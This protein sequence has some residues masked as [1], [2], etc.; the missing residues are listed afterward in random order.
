ME[1]PTKANVEDFLVVSFYCDSLE[2]SRSNPPILDLIVK[3]LLE[4]QRSLTRA[5][6]QKLQSLLVP[7][8]Q[9]T[10]SILRPEGEAR[11]YHLI[12]V[13]QILVINTTGAPA[14][15]IIDGLDQCED[16]F[17]L[18]LLRGLDTMFR[19]EETT[20]L[21]KV[22]FTS[23]M[24]DSVRGYAMK[25][26]HIGMTTELVEDD[27]QRV[28]SEEV[29]RI[30][31]AR[32]IKTIGGSSVSAVI[33][34]RSNGSFLFASSVLK[35]LWHIKDTG[36]NSVFTMVT[37][38]PPTM[39]AIYQ[40]D[41]E[42]LKGERPDL[43]RLIQFLCVGKRTLFIQEARNV[44]RL[45]NAEVT[46][47]YDVVGDLNRTCP[48]LVKFGGE[49]TVEL[50][51]QTL[52]D[53]ITNTYDVSEIHWCFAKTC[54]D[55]LCRVDWV[56]WKD[57]RNYR[58]RRVIEDR[59]PFLTYA[60]AWMG[61]H[62]KQSGEASAKQAWEIWDF[63]CS[64]AGVR[65][66][67]YGIPLS[68][69]RG[70][71]STFTSP[72][73][74][75]SSSP[76]RT[77]QLSL[78]KRFLVWP[79]QPAKHDS[80]DA[81]SSTSVDEARSVVDDG[82]VEARLRDLTQRGLPWGPYDR[83]PKPPLVLLTQWDLDHVIKELFFEAFESSP[84]QV[85]RRL[86]RSVPYISSRSVHNTP[87]EFRAM[88]NRVW[89]GTTAVHYA[90]AQY[91]SALRLLLPF[92][93]DINFPDDDGA[94]PL[95]LA[96]ASGEIEGVRA[97]L[98]AGAEV[99][100]VDEWNQT[101]LYSALHS[102]SAEVVRALL[103]AGA[104]VSIL[105][106]SGYSPLEV[107]ISK[108]HPEYAEILLEYSPDL[109]APMTTGQPPAFLAS[110]I[111]STSV[112][113]MLIPL[114]DVDQVWNGD[115]L[116]HKACWSGWE[117]VVKK[118]IKHRADL[119]VPPEHI[120]KA[121]PVAIAAENSC[122]AV[123]KAL[124][125][126]GALFDAPKPGMTGP[127]HIATS[128]GDVQSV[129]MLIRAGCEIDALNE[130]DKTALWIAADA[131][132]MELVNLLISLGADPNLPRSEP[133]LLVAADLSNLEMVKAVLSGPTT[134]NINARGE[135]KETPLGI[136]AGRNNVELVSYLMD[137]GA[138]VNLPSG[139]RGF[140]PLQ[141]ATLSRD[142]AVMLKLLKGGADTTIQR[143]GGLHPFHIACE[144][145][146]IDFIEAFLEANTG[147]AKEVVNLDWGVYRTPLFIAALRGQ[148]RATEI[149]LE[150]GANPNHKTDD[151]SSGGRK[152]IHAAAQSGKVD[153]FEMILK[154][155]A[156]PD[157]EIRDKTGRTPLVFACEAG[158]EELVEHLLK[159]GVSSDVVLGTEENVT[160]SIVI[161]GSAK[162]LKRVLE[163]NPGLD[164]D[165]P[166]PMNNKTPLVLA[167]TFGSS[168][169]VSILLDRGADM[170]RP[171]LSGETALINAI[172]Y[173]EKGTLEVLLKGEALDI[174]KQDAHGRNALQIAFQ[175]GSYA[176]AGMIW[177]TIKDQATESML[178]A[179]RDMFGYN[180]FDLLNIVCKEFSYAEC[181]ERIRRD[182]QLLLD[183]FVDRG[184]VWERLGKCF[185]QLDMYSF[186]NVGF[187][188]NV[189]SRKRSGLAPEHQVHCRL[190]LNFIETV[191]YT[192]M[193]C[194]TTDLC[195]KC[196]MRYPKLG[197]R[198]RSCQFHAFYPVPLPTEKVIEPP[199]YDD[200]G[201]FL[202]LS[203][204]YEV[205]DSDKD[206]VP[207]LDLFL[208]EPGSPEYTMRKEVR[209]LAEEH[210][211]GKS[212]G[213]AGP[214]L[215]VPEEKEERPMSPRSDSSDSESE[216]EDE[217][218]PEAPLLPP[219][220]L[221]WETPTEFQLR[222]F[223]DAVL[224]VFTVDQTHF[225]LR[226]WEW[227]RGRWDLRLNSDWEAQSKKK[228]FESL[229]LRPLHSR[230]PEPLAPK[231]EVYEYLSSLAYLWA[232]R[233]AYQ[234]TTGVSFLV[235]Q[236]SA[237]KKMKKLKKVASKVIK[238]SKRVGEVGSD[239]DE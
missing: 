2:S 45:H 49:G 185:L 118:L 17:I 160:S 79:D 158:S 214:D 135:L 155:V 163:Y 183:E 7:D 157:L 164:T 234:F 218:P 97:L 140:S 22:V 152:I 50:L 72:S 38:C 198:M 211:I 123:L 139:T 31:M 24:T 223:L 176:M 10:H 59:H 227:P 128:R 232:F 21:L 199:E 32:Q 105:A 95:V 125:A 9:K 114:I 228:E 235:F 178:L 88:I 191:R 186:A 203:P 92:V 233:P 78:Q 85:F 70:P 115:R 55:H 56:D 86:L 46:D 90:A 28:V 226:R 173:R 134:P 200:S 5:A 230:L 61:Y 112:L 175:A 26:P 154:N 69:T 119:N 221:E 150:K 53:F 15:L 156:E 6:K 182:A 117:G 220:P 144:M 58:D 27:I 229:I 40:Q 109:K 57:L 170:N 89:E 81:S 174:G 108:D 99:N 75:R 215:P 196:I 25:N 33:V 181:I 34:E 171:C 4:K 71:P 67:E 201:E 132:Q 136:A 207:C 19:R 131:N 239:V 80:S 93:N 167:A 166:R 216:E 195:D 129:T 142:E 168:E 54:L 194:C 236:Q 213:P 212:D 122:H 65:M 51:H 180:T 169:I 62:W 76:T 52:Y 83:T 204:I 37:S 159:Q 63:L 110:G 224:Q 47:N 43:F 222:F 94:T 209:A 1:S 202:G 145:G 172:I 102:K 192:C 8:R 74:S 103:D 66:R 184:P 153:V 124:L 82:T 116:L 11:F 120:P 111:E 138:D 161:G 3:A 205:S 133:P 137:R 106:N 41:M 29:E 177:A 193:H 30:I 13:I 42:R 210:F 217:E 162:V 35:E 231:L 36:A 44:L 189:V 197:F 130:A 121:T 96:A 206:E 187:Q 73:S 147:D 77:L 91:G 14:C 98:E 148:L 127:I 190:C 179:N 237:A 16:G 208:G 141:H 48:R 87:Q 149:L 60:N 225:E 238:P 39:E 100:H 143:N 20:P 113:E 188:R 126:A 12:E 23:R 64:P 68:R 104:D 107:I 165:V 18:R 146:F 219:E 101:A 151:E 84:R